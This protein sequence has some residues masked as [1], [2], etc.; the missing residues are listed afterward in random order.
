LRSD[1]KDG[2]NV[3]LKPDD[4]GGWQD[5]IRIA[6]QD[7]LTTSP[8]GFDKS[9]DVLYMMD[10]R[11]RDTG[12]LKSLDLKTNTE[13][14]IAANVTQVIGVVAPDLGVDEELVN[15]WIIGAEAQGCRFVLA[16]NKSDMPDFAALLARMQPFAALGYAVV[17]MSA[18]RDIDVVAGNKRQGALAILPDLLFRP[19]PRLIGG[20]EALAAALRAKK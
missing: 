4:K 10:S 11:G 13:K 16:A 12:A 3:I 6:M 17:P 7:T 14:L 19:T 8:L 1:E 15:R 5:Y 20:L 18:K 2:S 9:G